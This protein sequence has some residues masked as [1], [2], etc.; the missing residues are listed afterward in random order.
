MTGKKGLFGK[1]YGMKSA[2]MPGMQGNPMTTG[3]AYGQPMQEKPRSFWQGGDKFTLRDGI[4]GALA[5]VGD[6]L[7]NW[8]G[9]GGGA[10][11]SLMQSRM[12]PAQQ[13]AA[14]AAEQRK[15]AAEMADYRTKKS[16]DAE[17]DTG[18][19][20][21]VFDRALAGA[22]IDP[23]SPQ[24]QDLYRRR[25]ESMAQG[26]DE[27]VV[28]P[29]PGRG[30]YAG[31]KSGLPTAMG[32]AP[33]APVGRLTPIGPAQN[34]GGGATMTAEQYEEVVTVHGPAKAAEWA[35]RNNIRVAN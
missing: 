10:V 14:L 7:S 3:G 12:A 31:P 18:P 2:V 15:R 28:V 13:A 34:Q 24:G 23:S 1:P 35:R 33:T 8:S 29:I 11:N 17:F 27:F 26:Q 19:E 16:I 22:G 5:A 21:D 25:A 6:G 20:P 4:A 9:G 32:Q 30:T